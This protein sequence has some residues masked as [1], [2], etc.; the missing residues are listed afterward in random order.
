MRLPGMGGWADQPQPIT[1][2][3]RLGACRRALRIMARMD[4]SV[5]QALAKWPGVP[6]CRGW[7]GLDA[8]GQWWMRDARAQA[9]G[10]FASGLPG[11]RGALLRHEGLIAFIQRNYAAD[12]AGQWF[13]QNGPQRVYVELQAAPFIWRVQDGG[14]SVQAHD[15]RHAPQADAVFVDEQGRVFLQTALGFGLVH[16]QDML[17]VADAVQAGRWQP[18]PVRFADLP[19]RMGYVL[20]PQAQGG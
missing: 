3:A 1:A 7:L 6:G 11:A 12:E 5:K 9:L 8:R 16:T 13:F 20:S 14:R 18:Q 17:A 4:E 10:S 15:G 19:R 2:C